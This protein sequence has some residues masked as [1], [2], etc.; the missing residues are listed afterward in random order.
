[1]ILL[2]PPLIASVNAG[3]EEAKNLAEGT[4]LRLTQIRFDNGGPRLYLSIGPLS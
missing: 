3:P 4:I 1:M 2:S